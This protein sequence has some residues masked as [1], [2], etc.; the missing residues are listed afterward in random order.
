MT[1]KEI[2][3]A[4]F[5]NYFNQELKPFTNVEPYFENE[6]EY[7]SY[8]K[9]TLYFKKSV[10]EPLEKKG[11]KY[12]DS[13]VD[14]ASGDGEMS[15]ALALLGYKDITLFDLDQKRLDTGVQLIELFCNG[16]KAKRI[17]DTA[18][19]LNTN[20][21]VLISYQ[22]IEHLSDE[23]NYS[24]AKKQCQIDFLKNINK[25]I[26]KL[27][28]F[29]A[30]NRSFPMDGH[31]TGKPLFHLL[32]IG[33][34]KHLINK[35]IVKCS[36]AGIC[37]PVSISFLNKHLPA[38]KLNSNYYTYDNMVEYLDSRPSFDYMGVKIPPIDVNNL[39]QKKKAINMVA[40]LLGKNAQKI[41]PVLSVI[42]E[43]KK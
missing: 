42:Y 35:D 23:G 28:F 29:N 6:K 16:T 36:W 24:I 8:I 39:S 11:L 14:I 30:P 22:T 5:K 12:S 17:N 2:I 40:N 32:P 33:V 3:N 9:K 34:K 19:N 18:T 10:I 41:L 7:N 37:R 21:D 26:N 43:K 1:E 25:H 13:I 20:F 4:D 15:F 27:C 38:F 31:D